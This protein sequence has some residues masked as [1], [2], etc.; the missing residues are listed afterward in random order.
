M[1]KTVKGAIGVIAAAGL[2]AG[3]YFGYGI[4]SERIYP[5]VKEVKKTVVQEIEKNTGKKSEVNM[6]KL[7]ELYKTE[8]FP[9]VLIACSYLPQYDS[10]D[11]LTEEQLK[12]IYLS[13]LEYFIPDDGDSQDSSLTPVDPVN[14]IS[15]TNIN[16]EKVYKFDGNTF[17]HFNGI[18]GIQF[19][20][21]KL[22]SSKISYDGNSF[23][24]KGV[25][26][27]KNPVKCKIKTVLFDE[28]NGKLVLNIDKVCEKDQ[29][30]KKSGKT[31]ENVVLTLTDDN[32]IHEEYKIES[33]GNGYKELPQSADCLEYVVGRWE[34][35]A[36]KIA[37]ILENY[38]YKKGDETE[39]VQK[40]AENIVKYSSD[41]TTEH[42]RDSFYGVCE[43]A[44]ISRKDSDIEINNDK[45]KLNSKEYTVKD[46]YDDGFTLPEETLLRIEKDKKNNTMTKK[47][48]SVCEESGN[49][50]SYM[51]RSIVFEPAD[52]I[53]GYQIKS[54]TTE[55]WNDEYSQ[56]L[57]QIESETWELKEKWKHSQGS[58]QLELNQEIKDAWM[59]EM[60][61]IVARLKEKYPDDKDKIDQ[62]T[63]E[64]LNNMEEKV[65]R[66]FPE[67]D[68]EDKEEVHW[69]KNS[70]ILNEISWIKANCY[71]MIGNGLMD[72]HIEEIL[73]NN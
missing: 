68:E 48:L 60:Q 62:V 34:R 16:G 21:D 35:Y 46:S 63:E 13:S 65:K 22:N 20:F 73:E 26:N 3:G 52:N 4:V 27:Y 38:Q 41:E 45:V 72:D 32:S 66:M 10:V 31:E 39:I 54:I 67:P 23:T 58:E 51:T 6:E 57:E 9:Y 17:D 43:I 59:N 1:K 40:L 30:M 33:I 37:E 19:D 25:Q 5:E 28:E 55:E 53:Y 70:M 14:F 12:D 42:D 49:N 29:D 71:Q 24:V 56:E 7:I 36:I 64:Y 61:S 69:Y 2:V 47:Y 15:E 50:R 18:T 11:E 8:Y 44:G